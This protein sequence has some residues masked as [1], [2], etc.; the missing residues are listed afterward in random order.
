MSLDQE[1]LESKIK[2][3]VCKQEVSEDHELI[4]LGNEINFE[5]LF[6]IVADDLK[7]TAKGLW[8]LGR[9]LRVRVHLGVYLLQVRYKET[10]R[11]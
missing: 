3:Q 1:G 4:R 2:P 10:D 7:K 6:I 9:S 5:E 11:V 8:W